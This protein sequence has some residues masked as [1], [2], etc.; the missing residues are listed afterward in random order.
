ME[1][2]KKR[3]DSKK[4]FVFDFDGVLADSVNIKTSA[5]AE[6]YK[7]YGKSIVEKVINHHNS[8]GGMSRFKKFKYYHKTYLEKDIDKIQIQHLSN[9]FSNIVLKEVVASDW[10][11]GAK[12]YLERL[13]TDKI[14][15]EI[16]SAT[17]LD[18]LEIII[19]ERDMKKY[20][21]AVYGSPASK[22]DNL[23]ISL[24]KNNLIPE[25]V[26]FFGDAIADWEA[27]NKMGVLFVGVGKLIKDEL[28]YSKGNN[29]FIE[30]FKHA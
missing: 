2:L 26:V 6:I 28:K 22:Y 30:N 1:I 21:S 13:Y 8:N 3:L 23:E 4:L 25:D 19:K 27:A 16:I 18:E 15:C 7:P 29:I 9:Q 24:K 17:P 11:P 14:C 10:I 20:F 5:F 12:E